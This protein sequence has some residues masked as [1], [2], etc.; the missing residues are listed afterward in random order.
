MSKPQAE[1]KKL[2]R[3]KVK[4]APSTYQ[5]SKADKEQEFDMP[6]ASEETVRSAFFRP[7]EWKDT[8]R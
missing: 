3:R 5:P 1:A 6:E 8:D 2:N 7:I 4:V